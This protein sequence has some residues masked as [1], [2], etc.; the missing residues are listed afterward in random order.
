M[1]TGHCG[2]A[3]ITAR[4]VFENARLFF[5]QNMWHFKD[6]F[7]K[8]EAFLKR[9]DAFLKIRFFLKTFSEKLGL[10]FLTNVRIFQ[11]V[12]GFFK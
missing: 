6:I 11:K 12:R 10:F 4:L 5:L 2:K 1:W 3:A 9:L 7:R 8:M